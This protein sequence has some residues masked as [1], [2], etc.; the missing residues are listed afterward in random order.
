[1]V[2]VTLLRHAACSRAPLLELESSTVGCQRAVCT[3]CCCRTAAAAALL[4]L[5]Q[6]LEFI[7]CQLF[8][9]LLLRPEC[10]SASNARYV[11]RG[12]KQLDGWLLAEHS[13][14][15]GYEANTAAAAAAAAAAADGDAS[16]SRA[17][18]GARE[19]AEEKQ[20]QE[21]QKQGEAS[22]AAAAAVAEDADAG[23]QQ[24]PA[25]LGDFDNWQPAQQQQQQQ[26]RV[27]LWQWQQQEQQ[28]QQ[29]PLLQHDI[30]PEAWHA[31]SHIRQVHCRCCFSSSLYQHFV[32][33]CAYRLIYI[34]LC[35]TRASQQPD[36]L[37]CKD[38]I[39][40]QFS[41]ALHDTTGPAPTE[42]KHSG[43]LCMSCHRLGF[44]MYHV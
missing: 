26:S 12:L 7:N 38:S 8:N 19:T 43:M 15:A 9:Q 22:S 34:N 14:T 1:M 21:G 41:K 36:A 4:L 5:L 2:L 23:W 24:V 31:L 42:A 37:A 10:C 27:R 13:S 30:G 18:P 6:V 32:Y 17:D 16:A 29:G 3:C 11:L 35:S 44:N 39:S 33:C 40:L 20:Q 28:Q 25:D